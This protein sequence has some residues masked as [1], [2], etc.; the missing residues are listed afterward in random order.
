MELAKS[1]IDHPAIDFVHD[2]C[3]YQGE[4]NMTWL[5]L[6]LSR[7]INGVAKR[8]AEIS[9]HL[10]APYT[11]DAITNGIHAASWAAAPIAAMLDTYVPG[12]REDYFALRSALSIPPSRLWRA[13]L[14]AKRE[15]LDYANREANG[16]LDLDVFTIG[17]ARRMTAYKRPALLFSNLDRLRSIR[18]GA[19]A[20]QV[21]V[22]GKAHPRD[23]EGKS[24]IQGI[25]APATL[26]ETTYE[27]FF[28]PTTTSPSPA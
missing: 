8:H 16:G 14:D 15:L 20:I 11:I 13:H 23:E 27:S 5:A 28:F 17:F 2:L 6:N 12:W 19:G 4:L 26:W 18:Q 7:Y 9:R 24:I 10:F 1:V 21:I 3:C 22:A 25:F